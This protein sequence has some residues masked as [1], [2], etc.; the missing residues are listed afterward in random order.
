MDPENLRIGDTIED[1]PVGA[2]TITG[3][4]ERGYPQV[5]HVTVARLRRTDGV[6]FDPHGTY[7]K[8]R[9][10]A[11]DAALEDIAMNNLATEALSYSV[12]HGSRP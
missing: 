9:I 5:N 1:S 12:R 8:D 3:A 11:A 10:K 7:E 4:S 2:G 6:I